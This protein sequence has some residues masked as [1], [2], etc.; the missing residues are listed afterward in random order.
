[1]PPCDD[2]RRGRRNW[3]EW[4]PCKNAPDNAE[5]A[6]HCH[7]R[8]LFV[9]AAAVTAALPATLAGDRAPAQDY[10]SRQIRMIVAF[11]A[12]G[13]TDY[14]ARLIAD[15]ARTVLGQAIVVEN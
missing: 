12:G 15:R 2:R 13:T 10:P 9:V 1:M 11:S 8:R 7:F 4:G 3:P 6:V 14:V 5:D